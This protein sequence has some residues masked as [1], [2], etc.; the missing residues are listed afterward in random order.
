MSEFFGKS[1]QALQQVEQQQTT[2]RQAVV[3]GELRMAA[4][5]AEQAAARCELGAAEI[6]EHIQ[7]Y[8]YTLTTPRQFGDN[9]DGDAAA[10]R[11]AQAG[12][13]YLAEMRHVREVFKRMADTYRMAGGLVARTDE[14]TRQQFPGVER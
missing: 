14:A 9:A 2:L 1:Q 10:R 8:D 11:F 4:G 7:K 3:K 12:Q 6:W 13:A 5:V